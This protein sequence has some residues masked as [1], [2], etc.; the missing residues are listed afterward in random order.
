MI[1]QSLKMPGEKDLKSYL[2][3]S[4]GG[5]PDSLLPKGLK[6]AECPLLAEAVQKSSGWYNTKVSALG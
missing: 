5:Q 1:N 2:W 4:Y 3:L 6:F